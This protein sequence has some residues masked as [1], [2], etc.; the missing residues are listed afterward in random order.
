MSEFQAEKILDLCPF[1]VL[2][3]VGVRDTLSADT[4]STLVCVLIIRVCK[5]SYG[6]EEGPSF[7]E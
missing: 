2:T 7:P 6:S 5:C 1:R 4:P 3:L